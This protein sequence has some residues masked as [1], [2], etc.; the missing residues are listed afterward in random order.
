MVTFPDHEDARS[1]FRGLNAE[2]AVRVAR[3]LVEISEWYGPNPLI[4]ELWLTEQLVL[5]VRYRVGAQRLAARFARLDVH[6]GTGGPPSS[7]VGLASDLF[8]TLHTRREP[9]AWT[10]RDGY[11]WWGDP[12]S[13]GWPTVLSGRRILSIS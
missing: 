1:P 11:S 4:D 8:Q 3:D 10:D 6:P 12:P 13:G 5:S 9:D 7:S 2:W